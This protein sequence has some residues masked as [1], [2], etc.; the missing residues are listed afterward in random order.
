M[1]TRKHKALKS[2]HRHKKAFLATIFILGIHLIAAALVFCES[3][4]F[5]ASVAGA[6]DDSKPLNLPDFSQVT[7]QKKHPSK[8]TA[9]CLA[10]T[11]RR[12]AQG[13]PGYESCLLE[14]SPRNESANQQESTFHIEGH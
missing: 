12:Y 8:V 3:D 11:G 2:S 13:E 5:A 7:T 1:K 14:R 6:P 4:A 9:S 10:Q